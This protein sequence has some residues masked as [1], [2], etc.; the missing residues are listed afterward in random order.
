MPCQV[1]MP[2]WSK[3]SLDW[4][5]ES[6]IAN[7]EIA[8]RICDSATRERRRLI[9]VILVQD[10]SGLTFGFAYTQ[11]RLGAVQGKLSKLSS[12][13]YP[14]MLHA[15]VIVHAPSFM[16][17]IFKMGSKFLSQKVLDKMKVC[18]DTED[19]LAATHLRYSKLPSFL[20]GG[21]DWDAEWIPVTART[22]GR[23]GAAERRRLRQD[24][25]SDSG[26]QELSNSL[27]C[28]GTASGGDGRAPGAP[29]DAPAAERDDGTWLAQKAG[30]PRCAAKASRPQR[31]PFG[32]WPQSWPKPSSILLALALALV[33]SHWPSSRACH[34]RGWCALDLRFASLVAPAHS[35]PQPA[36]KRRWFR[37]WHMKSVGSASPRPP[38]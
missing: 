18:S 30:A 5:F 1:D 26:S 9:K 31:S 15:V 25:R 3:A 33:M 20:G 12:Y 36:P 38:R 35:A 34:G 8:Y 13:V 29:A 11:Y 32:H 21:F 2:A 27:A 37:F 10:L 7:R 4:H 19:I 23:Q 17:T 6:G 22:A 16:S 14:Q 24:R 28:E